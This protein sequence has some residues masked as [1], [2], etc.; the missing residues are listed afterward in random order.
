MQ[1]AR[2]AF[3]LDRALFFKQAQ[4]IDQDVGRFLAD[5]DRRLKPFMKRTLS[6]IPNVEP[7][8][9]G[10]NYQIMTGGKRIRA[11][12]CVATCELFG[13][14][15]QRALS[16]AAAIEHLQNFTLIHDDIADGDTLRRYRESIWKKFGIAHGINIG[17]VFVPFASLAIL[18]S[19]YS[20][21]VKL[22]LLRLVS[23][24]G[25]EMVEG[26]TLDINMRKKNSVKVE[27]YMDCTE[28]KTGAFL[29]MATVGGAIIGGAD[30][31]SLAALRNFSLLA[32]TA[33]QIKDDVLDIEGYKGRDIGSDILEGKRTLLVIHAA[34][35]ASEADRSRLFQILNKNRLAK[36]PEDVQWVCELFRRTGAIDFAELKAMELVYEACGYIMTFP[37]S[38]AKY[39]LLRISRYLSRRIQ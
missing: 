23:E 16:Y 37:D 11:A 34:H 13:T 10:L 9:K 24:C 2:S 22:G 39:R 1:S 32:G 35:E 6:L 3:A 17:D 7:L 15:Y 14:S 21:K 29:A 20:E 27:E 33:F 30:K 38:E 18:D 31:K 12:L 8:R 4:V 25:L 36:T 26:Q 28:K 19:A 5:V